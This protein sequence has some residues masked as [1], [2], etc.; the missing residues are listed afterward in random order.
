[1]RLKWTDLFDEIDVIESLFDYCSS[2]S[3]IF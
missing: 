1:M 2:K 3:I